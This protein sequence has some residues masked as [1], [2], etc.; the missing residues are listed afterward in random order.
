MA[1]AEYAVASVA[2][3]FRRNETIFPSLIPRRGIASLW[4]DPIR[5]AMVLARDQRIDMVALEKN[6][7]C[8]TEPCVNCSDAGLWAGAR[9]PD[10]CCMDDIG[11]C[12]GQGLCLII[13]FR[14]QTLVAQ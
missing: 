6:M 9:D 4:L 14:G 7:G 12:K 11:Q 1:P 5:V 13:E 3:A 2:M 8:V 10:R